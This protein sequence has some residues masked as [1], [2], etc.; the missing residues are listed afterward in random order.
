MK[1]VTFLLFLVSSILSANEHRL[2]ISGFTKHEESHRANGDRYNEFNYGAGYE[3]TTFKDYNAL[4]LGTNVTALKD[5]FDEWQY[6]LSISPNIRYKL[7]K[8][9]AVS[10]GIASFLMLK[11]DNFKVGVTNDEAE[12]DLLVGAAP[13]S[14]LYYKD[15]SVNLAYVPPVSFG[16]L[17]IVGFVIMYFG[18]K[19]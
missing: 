10:V 4:Y 18:W 9:L 16:D 2:L 13:L 5:S 19:F 14:S 11:K 1:G 3:F 17:D 6:T 12:Y 7:A 8:D 15:L